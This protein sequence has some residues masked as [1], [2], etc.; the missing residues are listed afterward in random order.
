MKYTIEGFSQ[1]AMLQ[2]KKSIS[3]N[4]KGIEK[5]RI[6]KLDFIDLVILRW[7]VDFYPNMDRYS[8]EGVEYFRISY[9]YLIKELP[10]LDMSKRGVFERLKK[11]V[12][13]KIL[14]HLYVAEQF[15]NYYSFGV[16]YIKLVTN[17]HDTFNSLQENE[18]PQHTSASYTNND[19]DMAYTYVQGA[20]H[21][22][23][24]N[25]SIINKSINNIS[26]SKSN[27][28]DLS[29]DTGSDEPSEV[30]YGQNKFIHNENPMGMFCYEEE[31][32]QTK[33]ARADEDASDVS[34]ADSSMPETV[35][36]TKEQSELDKLNAIKKF[37]GTP[38]PA[39]PK[40]TTS[41]FKKCLKMIYD[42]NYSDE[43]KS[44]L[45]EFLKSLS[46]YRHITESAFELILN[47]LENSIEECPYP[48]D[49]GLMNFL[50]LKV[51]KGS[52][53][54]CYRDFYKIKPYELTQ[55][56][57]EFRGTSISVERKFND[58]AKSVVYDPNNPDH[59]L[60]TNPDG[61]PMIF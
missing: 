27:E 30:S 43:V 55:W 48:N 37:K 8:I 15:T 52:H 11:L 7:L 25:K 26:I 13:F 51:V 14:N 10:G 41:P 16:N 31:N 49:E 36:T 44:A 53:T 47:N 28:L 17:S 57:S 58:D 18:Y 50:R 2:F 33:T 24:S 56:V 5:S 61:T 60:A 39:K 9:E 42:A 21:T 32:K 20:Q 22:S 38:K 19:N 29:I 1:E 35:D 34:A 45:V 23:A 54:K 46:Q 40:S 4:D 6:I 3:Y 59:Q 12:E